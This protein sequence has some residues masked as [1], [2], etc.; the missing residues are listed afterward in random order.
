MA[1]TPAIAPEAMISPHA[2]TTAAIIAG[3]LPRPTAISYPWMRPSAFGSGMLG[4]MSKLGR[5]KRTIHLPEE[6]PWA[7]PP[8]PLPEKRQADAEPVPAGMPDRL[9]GPVP[10][11]PAGR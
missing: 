3:H 6:Q 10:A 2:A 8:Q 4:A 7:I 9:P 11:A 1:R 5:H